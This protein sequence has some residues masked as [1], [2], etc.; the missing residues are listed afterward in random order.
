MRNSNNAHAFLT[1]AADSTTLDMP[2]PKPALETLQ[3]LGAKLKLDKAGNVVSVT[4]SATNVSDAELAQLRLMPSIERLEF[5]ADAGGGRMAL[6][7]R[8]SRHGRL[9]AFQASDGLLAYLDFL[10][11][12]LAPDKPAAL[13]FDEPD[14]HLH[15]SALHRLVSILEERALSGTV[16]V[17]THSDRFLDHLSD[18]AASVVVCEPGPEGVSM[19]KLDEASL[20]AWRERYPMSAL[21]ARGQLDPANAPS[22]R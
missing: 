11:A 5:P 8:D 10:A 20:S 16:I 4:L 17:A 15:P 14:A 3:R 7:F 22:G 2:A 1:R 19:T 12:A 6:S 18:P 21:R 13:A 9:F